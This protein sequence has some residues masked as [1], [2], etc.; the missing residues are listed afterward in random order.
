[1]LK[2]KRVNAGEYTAT[3]GVRTFELYCKSTGLW[4]G[5]VT[6]D[7][8]SEGA[9]SYWARKKKELV[10]LLEDKYFK[11]PQELFAAPQGHFLDNLITCTTKEV[12]ERREALND[13]QG[14]LA[15]LVEAR[16]ILTS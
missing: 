10:V 8:K 6:S 15:D 2:F 1:M 3:D 16:K 14:H 5:L 9:Q 4:L 11:S 7:K 13:A 12:E